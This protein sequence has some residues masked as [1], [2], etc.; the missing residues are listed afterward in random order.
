MMSKAEQL[1]QQI[2]NDYNLEDRQV[3]VTADISTLTTTYFIRL[4]SVD[5]YPRFIIAHD[6]FYHIQPSMVYLLAGEVKEAVE[7]L[8]IAADIMKKL[9][10]DEWENSNETTDRRSGEL[11]LSKVVFSRL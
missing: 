1:K 2:C 11:I 9:E 4:S 5:A 7:L 8:T 6:I 10:N 3:E